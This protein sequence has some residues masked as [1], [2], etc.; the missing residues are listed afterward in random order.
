MVGAAPGGFSTMTNRGCVNPLYLHQ[1][2]E[3]ARRHDLQ[4]LSEADFFDM[5]PHG[6][7]SCR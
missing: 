4:F 7:L 1:F 6:L 5:V 3:Q 2:M